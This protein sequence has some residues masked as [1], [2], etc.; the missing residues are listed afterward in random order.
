MNAKFFKR[1]GSAIALSM[2]L[3]ILSP[4]TAYAAP[5]TAKIQP[6]NLR[7]D[8]EE[9]EVN[10]RIEVEDFRIATENATMTIE[11]SLVDNPN[12]LDFSGT[13]NS[14]RVQFHNLPDKDECCLD[15]HYKAILENGYSICIETKNQGPDKTMVS[16]YIDLLEDS[17][18]YEWYIEL[19][20][21]SYN[22]RYENGVSYDLANR[23]INPLLK[24]IPIL[25]NISSE[26]GGEST[27][28][29]SKMQKE[30]ESKIPQ[31]FSD[32]I[33]LKEFSRVY[34][35]MNPSQHSIISSELGFRVQYYPDS[36]YT[37]VPFYI[38][39]S[40]TPTQPKTD[41]TGM[42]LV[43]DSDYY[44]KQNNLSFDGILR[45]DAVRDAAMSYIFTHSPETDFYYN[46]LLDMYRDLGMVRKYNSNLESDVLPTMKTGALGS[47]EFNVHIYRANNPDL[48]AIFGDDLEAYYYHYINGGKAEGRIAN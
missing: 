2:V 13:N 39:G 44:V 42:D 7:R 22:K 20:E 46:E 9:W 30:I 35:M 32:S 47:A 48:V 36:S 23:Y 24:F 15:L 12:S 3:P 26:T 16:M 38:Q 19:Y 31:F 33:K 8:F 28:H 5:K 27:F 4:V 21:D 17:R 29:N 10:E 1:L 43:F 45:L 37:V 6:A 25:V 18:S 11:G 41:A 34:G 14:L 40:T